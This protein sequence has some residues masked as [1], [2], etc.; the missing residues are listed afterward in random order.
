MPDT[1]VVVIGAGVG[2]LVSA[3]LLA[4]RGCDVTV[5]DAASGPGGQ[6]PCRNG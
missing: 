3:A 4:V 1:R 5:V 6:A 2:G